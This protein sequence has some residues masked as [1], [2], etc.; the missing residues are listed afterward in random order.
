MPRTSLLEYFQQDSRPSD[1]IAVVWRSGYRTIRW[2]YEE[3]FRAA[4][5]FAWELRERSVQ[6]GDRVLL[7]AENSGWWVAAFLGCT[8]AGAMCVP[9]DLAAD[10]GFAQRV[11]SLAAIRL[12]ALGK[13]LALPGG[14]PQV[15]QLENFFESG[16]ND[17]EEMFPSPSIAGGDPLQ[18]V[19]TSGT[20]AEPRGVVLTHSN[21]LASIQ[22]IEQEIHRYRRYERFLHPLRI[23]NLLPLSHVFGQMLGI[24]I[25]QILG[26][27][28][29][30]LDT[31]NPSEV[32][33]AIK[34][35]RV[36]VLVT[37]P[38]LLES[39]R[40]QTERDLKTRGRLEKF[41]RSFRASHDEHFLKR[42]WR[43]RAIRR[44][45]G[46]KFLAI[47][48]GGA[49]LPSPVEE[50][51]KRLGYAV[52]QGYGLTETT[53]LIS[54]N[55]PFRLSSGSIGKAMP[56]LEMKLS[57]DGE[58]LVRGPN[59]AESYW[60]RGD[61]VSVPDRDGWFHTGDLGER[62]EAG[63]LYFKGRRKNVI[64]TA[65]GL[66]VYP[67]D[68]E[69]E[70]RK[71]HSVR[72]C[73]VVGL[74]R[75]GN[76]QPCAV[77]LLKDS[78]NKS[79]ADAIVQ[80]AN[81]RLAPF[82]RM[83]HW[84]V[85]PDADF[86]RTPTQKPVLSRILGAAEAAFA[87]RQSGSFQAAPS[88][89]LGELLKGISHGRLA[90]NE[91]APL[92]LSSIDRVE[93]LS[94]LEDRYQVDLSETEFASANSL[95]ALERLVAQPS[96]GVATFHYPRWAQSWP[97]RLLRAAAFTVLARPALLI[98]GW[99]RV[100]GRENLR[101]AEGPV[102]VV[103]NHVTYFD[104]ALILHALP[105]RLRRRLA[106]AMDGERLESMRRPPPDNGF[107]RSLLNRFKYFA[108]VALF[109]VFPLPRQAGFRKSFAFVGDLIDR[110]W[111]VLIFP[112]GELTRD[113]H[114]TPFRAGIG[115]LATGLSAPVVPARLGGLFAL[116][117]A[118]KRRAPRGQITIALGSPMPINTAR[119]AE[120]IAREIQEQVAALGA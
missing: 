41:Q 62:D 54:L 49:T 100:S 79:D 25:P 60:Q 70:L 16:E 3:L 94:A 88:G 32:V 87:E 106:V 64:V 24:F 21:I 18:I 118:G 117:Q 14:V 39:L 34:S 95:E 80:R 46:W 15:L 103:A 6:K 45:F 102:L 55:H 116:K 52:I 96:Q 28:A 82:Q 119:P 20:T 63:N 89:V 13:G 51:W 50:F 92:Q 83:Q 76:A 72:D 111:S 26:A 86:P 48:C 10:E 30:F 105:A 38:R 98:L 112:E 74:E 47:V 107:F 77:L 104:P 5:R 23:L 11:A 68:L 43:F 17:Q 37:V 78:A 57:E 67:Q 99:P 19:F 69:A 73:V 4:T 22:P 65:E 101:A 120:E 7:W 12:A 93:L 91:S 97:A 85:W 35:E 71:D 61:V 40:D 108:V 113:G 2:P 59:V 84:L 114:I 56:G 53:A 8:L 31:L 90:T 44:S 109:N 27:T 81:E 42:W 58:I 36:S 110:G 9:M 75:E 29:V 1:E 33:R 115:L 66:N